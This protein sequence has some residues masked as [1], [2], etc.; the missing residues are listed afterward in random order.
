MNTAKFDAWFAEQRAHGL[1]DIKFAVVA[2]KGVSMEA[3]QTEVLMSEA[4]I[5]TGLVRSAPKATSMMPERI[6]QFVAAVN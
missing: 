1:V 5:Q 4:A 6:S 2:G 3:V